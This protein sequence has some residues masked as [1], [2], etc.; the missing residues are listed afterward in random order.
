MAAD[1]TPLALSERSRLGFEAET[2][3]TVWWWKVRSVLY[4]P[5]AVLI[6]AVGSIRRIHFTLYLPQLLGLDGTGV[7][8]S[9][10]FFLVGSV[11]F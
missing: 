4:V 7:V 2:G 10:V 3:G 6:R 8:S 5:H 1:A 11:G 9:F